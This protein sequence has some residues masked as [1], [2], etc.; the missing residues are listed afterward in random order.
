[1]ALTNHYYKVLKAALLD[2]DKN[3]GG[4]Y[5]PNKVTDP[6]ATASGFNYANL[7]S[8][9]DSLY[10]ERVAADTT[11]SSNTD[12]RITEA[13]E[14]DYREINAALAAVPA[15]QEEITACT[16]HGITCTCNDRAASCACN[17]EQAS[18][19]CNSV[20]T[21]VTLCTCNTV[22]TSNTQT[23]VCNANYTCTCDY[24]AGCSCNTVC[25]AY[26]ICGCD[27]V[28]CVSLSGCAG[29]YYTCSSDWDIGG[30]NCECMMV[31]SGD[32][33][34]TC[35]CVSNQNLPLSCT[36]NTQCTAQSYSCSCQ[37]N[38]TSVTLGCTSQILA[39]T[40]EGYVEACTALGFNCECNNRDYQIIFE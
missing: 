26:A 7:I 22:C 33:T 31:E 24:N 37:S 1:L 8:L 30:T 28:E 25:S 34:S 12:F 10:G 23:C 36:C 9:L 19:S 15:F 6:D 11:C 35:S 40:A 17:D 32:S 18:C 27:R 39:C 2:K 20:C 16:A 3:A 13:S 4:T 38:C 5:A 29:E 14:Y 21:A